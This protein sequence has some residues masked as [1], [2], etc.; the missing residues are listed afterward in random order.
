MP[1]ADCLTCGH[2]WLRWGDA[3]KGTIVCH[4]NVPFFITDY[5]LK[6]IKTYNGNLSFCGVPFDFCGVWKPKESSK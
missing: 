4:A 1:N 5:P 2:G 3:T 6:H